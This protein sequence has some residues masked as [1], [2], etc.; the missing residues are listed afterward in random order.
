MDFAKERRFIMNDLDVII[1]TYLH[2]NMADIKFL[3]STTPSINKLTHDGETLLTWACE[4]RAIDLVE[5]LLSNNL[6]N[7]NTPNSWGFS[8]LSI[9][10]FNNCTEIVELLLNKNAKVNIKLLIDHGAHIYIN[11][12]VS[13]NDNFTSIMNTLR[14]SLEPSYGFNLMHKACNDNNIAVIDIL[15]SK[16]GNRYIN[17]PDEDNLYPIHYA[18][19]SG[20]SDA[21]N[22]LLQSGA[23]P[24][25]FSNKKFSPIEF[26]CMAKSY[27]IVKT[28]IE[29]KANINV[30]DV[31]FNTPLIYSCINNSS[32]LV[33]LLIA[34]NVNVNVPNKLG[35][36][37]LMYACMLKNL[38]L[39]KILINAEADINKLN[40]CGCNALYFALYHNNTDMVELLISNNISLSFLARNSESQLVKNLLNCN[41][42]K[43]RAIVSLH[44]FDARRFKD[45]LCSYQQ[46]HGILATISLI[47][48]L[49]SSEDYICCQ[50]L[51][52]LWTRDLAAL[53]ESKADLENRIKS[54]N[55]LIRK[56]FYRK[57]IEICLNQ[58]SRTQKK[59]TN[60]RTLLRTPDTLLREKKDCPPQIT[61]P[62]S[63]S[64]E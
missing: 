63:I 38:E 46:Q 48:Q 21:V 55:N 20:A 23:D 7:V 3:L 35:N 54:S 33:S 57:D 43:V 37:P 8:P 17:I 44:L 41:D 34:N 58:I 26:A 16:Y 13:S 27:N 56:M 40:S 31:F 9:A 28:L 36:T 64:L 59:L 49:K 25:V 22:K 6:I 61:I 2:G 50:K 1:D 30:F 62:K 4:N 11:S 24:N 29:H 45:S 52:K 60:I 10:C 42:P 32:E 12:F 18:C 53:I 39:A 14:V 47:K 51:N 5:K 15:I 19:M